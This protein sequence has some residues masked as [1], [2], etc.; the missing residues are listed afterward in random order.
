MLEE[1]D[2]IPHE[3]TAGS[4]KKKL[5]KDRVRRHGAG[6]ASSAADVLSGRSAPS[7]H[8]NDD[9]EFVAHIS[10][11]TSHKSIRTQRAPSSRTHEDDQPILGCVA[12]TAAVPASAPYRATSHPSTPLRDTKHGAVYRFMSLLQ[13]HG[14]HT[15]VGL[16]NALNPA[17]PTYI[18]G[19]RSFCKSLSK[20]D[21]KVVWERRPATAHHPTHAFECNSGRTQGSRLLTRRNPSHTPGQSLVSRGISRVVPGVRP[22]MGS[23]PTPGSRKLMTAA[24]AAQDEHE[25]PIP[26]PPDDFLP[27]GLQ[28]YQMW[29]AACQRRTVDNAQVCC[30]CMDKA[31]DAMILPCHHVVP[32]APCAI[33]VMNRHGECPMCRGKILNVV[34]TH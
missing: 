1:N 22:V 23:R 11:M 3:W 28:K 34:C 27:S 24:S 6:V 2:D 13:R 18:S 4:R 19:V 32:C 10:H 9:V 33:M 7:V 17:S 12:C 31:R 26:G 30:V 20:N 21:C 16:T 15:Q 29:A 8:A 5:V 25:D 14:I